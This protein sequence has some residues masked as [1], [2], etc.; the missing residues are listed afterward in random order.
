PSASE[1]H[2][3]DLIPILLGLILICAFAI[4][5]SVVHSNVQAPE[6]LHDRSDHLLNRD[7]CA[8]VTT[9]ENRAPAHIPDRRCRL[10]PDLLV[11]IDDCHIGAGHRQREGAASSDPHGTAGNQC[12][13]TA[14]I[15]QSSVRHAISLV[16]APSINPAICELLSRSGIWPT[17]SS[18]VSRTPVGKSPTARGRPTRSCVP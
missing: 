1:I 11:A 12:L 14:Q 16:R 5:A 3:D 7:S 9:Y 6:P 13:S 10:V 18:T 15:K 4:D 2:S 8:H 17:P